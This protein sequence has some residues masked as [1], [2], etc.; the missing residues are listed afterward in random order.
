MGI[1]SK[2][3]KLMRAGK[4]AL[5]VA[6][7]SV[8]GL[9]GTFA[10]YVTGATIS[11]K[12]RVAKWGVT[13][14]PNSEAA[15]SIFKAEY[16]QNDNPD[17]PLVAQ[18]YNI[19]AGQ[20]ADLIFAP[21]LKVT[22]KVSESQFKITGTSETALNFLGNAS[23]N[24][25][26]DAEKK[27]IVEKNGK[28]YFYCPLVITVDNK[29]IDIL[30]LIDPEQST[31]FVTLKE[32]NADSTYANTIKQINDLLSQE[33]GKLFEQP[34]SDLVAPNTDLSGAG[35]IHWKSM[36]T[37][38][39]EWKYDSGTARLQDDTTKTLYS[40]DV[41]DT[42]MGNSVAGDP[43]LTGPM[44]SVGVGIQAV[45]ANQYPQS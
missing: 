27:W 31:D 34:I 5:V 3:S 42:D 44:I 38:T 19:S 40:C 26:P 1:I 7:I 4:I 21:G 13:I 22:G 28:T 8:V 6:L 32:I 9:S 14:E 45:Q 10:K 41:F 37:I 17:D 11:D 12:A 29:T 30:K 23:I 35:A 25:D 33:L 2:D 39:F 36:P 43:S 24:L 16:H 20:D 18:A 15:T